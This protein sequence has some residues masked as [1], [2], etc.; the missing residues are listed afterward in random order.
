[1]YLKE[2]AEG[3][4]MKQLRQTQINMIFKQHEWKGIKASANVAQ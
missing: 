3:N 2:S 1:M 4:S